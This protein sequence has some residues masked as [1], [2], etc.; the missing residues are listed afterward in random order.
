VRRSPLGWS[1]LS[2]S[3]TSLSPWPSSLAFNF[4]A[5]VR[6]SDVGGACLLQVPLRRDPNR[7]ADSRRSAGGGSG[8]LPA[9]SGVSWV[10]PQAGHQTHRERGQSV[11]RRQPLRRSAAEVLQEADGDGG[12]GRRGAAGSEFLQQ[13]ADVNLG[14]G[15]R[16]VTEGAR[17]R[18]SGP[19]SRRAD[20]GLC[21]LQ[22][23][24]VYG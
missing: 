10:W 15:S 16:H 17:P 12:K 5:C 4:A 20:A 2:W 23:F 7:G 9:R 3:P 14:R 19:A 8:A 6:P 22:C 18:L 13:L 1:W 21:W 24:R 11:Y